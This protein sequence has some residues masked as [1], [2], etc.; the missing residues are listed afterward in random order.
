M[1]QQKDFICITVLILTVLLF[2]ILSGISMLNVRAA[3]TEQEEMETPTNDA[4]VLSAAGDVEINEKNFPDAGFREYLQTDSKMLK[5]HQDPNKFTAAEISLVTVLDMRGSGSIV[6]KA[7]SLAGI[8]H[9]ENL[10]TLHC[11]GVSLKTIDV[12]KNTKLQYLQCDQ[13]WNL[14]SLNVKNCT[15]LRTLYCQ[16]CKLIDLDLSTNS[17]LE[18]LWCDQN[19]LRTLDTRNMPELK[20]LY[21]RD[22]QL[23]ILDVGNNTK[24]KDLRCGAN[25]LTALDVR[26]NEL[27][28]ILHCEKNQLKEIDI[29]G[30]PY[31]KGLSIEENQLVSLDASDCPELGSLICRD[32]QLK[33]LKITGNPK[34]R[35]LICRNNQLTE[36]DVLD[37]EALWQF[38][39]RNNQLKTLDVSNSKNLNYLYFSENKM[40]KID[41][42][43]NTQ[44]VTFWC[45][46]NQLKT[47]D[48]SQNTNLGNLDC[49]Q[50]QL[51]TLDLSQNQ[52]LQ[53]FSCTNNH[54]LSLQL[55]ASS[56]LNLPCEQ[57]ITVMLEDGKT[58]CDLSELDPSVDRNKISN[59]QGASFTDSSSKILTNFQSGQ[60]VT[61]TYDCGNS[62]SMNVTLYF[63]CSNRWITELTAMSGWCY[64]DAPVSPQAE[65]LYGEVQYLYS[66]TRNSETYQPEIPQEAGIW[67][68]KAFVP[69]TEEYAGLEGIPVE[70]EI[71]KAVPTELI[72]PNGLRS[73]HG[74]L[75]SSVTLPQG[76]VWVNP[77]EKVQ[78]K[79]QNYE[80]MYA[81]DDKNYDY[82][83]VEGYDTE[84][85][86]VFRKLTITVTAEEKNR[87]DISP[88]ITEIPD[89]L[90]DVGLDTAEKISEKLCQV[91]A[92]KQGYS[93]KNTVIYDV[94]LQV[95]LDGGKTWE[96]VT[97]E[98]FPKEGLSVLL[99]YPEGT[100]RSDH[101]FIITHM[102]THEMNGHKP[103][104]VET[105]EAEKTAE[106]LQ[107]TVY[108]LSPIAIAWKSI[109]T[110]NGPDDTKKPE[111]GSPSTDPDSK[112]PETNSPPA[113]SGNKK[114]GTDP[115]KSSSP[116]T[117]DSC[118]PGQWVFWI[119]LAGIGSYMLLQKNRRK[120]SSR[121]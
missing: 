118:V 89:S 99:P 103:G 1:K 48:L 44:I 31:L 87:V 67:Y 68:V 41:L 104:E 65:S 102:F 96:D 6:G 105:L 43:Q 81:V 58:E 29:K 107:F 71:T 80:A 108:S 21:C 98:N 70:F 73:V 109:H 5:L 93:K 22:N 46:N 106:G 57:Q 50:N 117:G 55:P 100:N 119:F 94:K 69:E 32:N 56:N 77:N 15:E 72:L 60:E 114:E 116:P 10:T 121:L 47:L 95:S 11:N 16:Q 33:E 27:L 23:T 91:I 111:T 101:D 14:T 61:Y 40:T 75:L 92:E 7:E 63:K 9:F 115:L 39:T 17:K 53:T 64:G 38:D 110:D 30:Y 120:D 85:H 34:L 19:Q 25:A 84:K 90:K 62:L 13:T 82:T 8:E 78:V 66:Q 2:H 4:K 12:S 79:K 86:A 36:L 97:P 28:E 112:K 49:S 35:E 24:L 3:L 88:G 42:S 20:Q 113:D 45:Q 18:T 59:L 83:K 37:N 74:S 26:K 54:L 52:K 76:W 51:Q